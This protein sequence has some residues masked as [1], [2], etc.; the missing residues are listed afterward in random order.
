MSIPHALDIADLN[1][2]PHTNFEKVVQF[3][4]IFGVPA[5]QA[6][7]V[8]ICTE[9]PKLV[10]HRIDLIT[11]EVQ[12]LK[13]AFANND[14]PEIIDALSD[15]LYTVYGMGV[16]IG[17][18]LDR[19]FELVHDSN[20]SKLC[21]NEQEARATVAWYKEQYEKGLLPYDS[22]AYRSGNE[23]EEYWVIYNESSGK[24]LKNLN[25]KPVNF[26]ECVI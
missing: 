15:I 17:V 19:S 3:N 25:Y 23:E 10:Q 24:I 21:S 12:E 16:S 1:D 5:F 11:E 18:N 14:F 8:K 26:I 13:D 2:S 4:K 22:P 9:N 7:Q 6:P 20:M